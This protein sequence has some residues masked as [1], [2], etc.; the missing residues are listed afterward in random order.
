MRKGLILYLLFLLF[1]S[2]G[3]IFAQSVKE[4]NVV[5]SDPNVKALEA[6]GDYGTCFS[7]GMSAPG[8]ITSIEYTCEGEA[9]GWV[10]PC[11]DGGKCN[12]HAYQ[13]ELSGTTA[14][15]FGWTNSGNPKAVYKFKIH[16]Q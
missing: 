11:P 7:I 1:C 6:C 14:T 2:G 15:W 5:K 16:Y 10:H 13:Y 8:T 9:C 3:F 12:Q 4:Y